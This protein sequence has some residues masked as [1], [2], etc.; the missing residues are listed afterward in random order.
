LHFGSSLGVEVD[1]YHNMLI[2]CDYGNF[3][4]S[5]DK[6]WLNLLLCFRSQAMLAQAPRFGQGF[7]TLVLRQ[8]TLD[9]LLPT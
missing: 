2:L 8:A 3:G 6:G 9:F 4:Y 7:G 1:G 5:K